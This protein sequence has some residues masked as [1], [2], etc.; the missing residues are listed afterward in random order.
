MTFTQHLDL[1]VLC[2]MRPRVSNSGTSCCWKSQSCWSANAPTWWFSQLQPCRRNLSHGG[3]SLWWWMFLINNQLYCW[4]NHLYQHNMSTRIYP[5]L[6]KMICIIANQNNQKQ[7]WSFLSSQPGSSSHGLQIRTEIL[8][9]LIQTVSV[10]RSF[11]TLK[12]RYLNFVNRKSVIWHI[13][14]FWFHFGSVDSVA[15]C[16]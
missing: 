8:I 10:L 13:T 14:K 6:Q 11:L 4:N 15:V 5:A 16:Y 1:Y 9:L 3:K 7:K 12:D 2:C